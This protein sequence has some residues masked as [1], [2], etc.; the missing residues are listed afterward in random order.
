LTADLGIKYD[1]GWG[2]M[3]YYEAYRSPY[4]HG[5]PNTVT[6]VNVDDTDSYQNLTLS[7][8]LTYV[9]IKRLSLLFGSM[10]TLPLDPLNYNMTGTS[11]GGTGTTNLSA[12]PRFYEGGASRGYNTRGWNYGG[13][14]RIKFEF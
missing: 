12:Q 2:E 1:L 11:T 5:D 8:S 10:V 7:T 6:Y 14:L 9:P 13:T 4:A 3:S